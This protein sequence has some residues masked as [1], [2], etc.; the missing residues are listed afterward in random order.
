MSEDEKKIIELSLWKLPN[1]ASTLLLLWWFYS[2]PIRF[3][4][5]ITL[6]NPQTCRKMYVLTFI[7]CIIWIGFVAYLI[8][9]ML[10]VIGK[11]R[12]VL[13]NFNSFNDVFFSFT[14]D[15][16]GIAE[17]ILGLTVLAVGGCTPEMITGAIMA[18]RGQAGTGIA[19][20]LGASS[21]AILLSLGLPWFIKVLFKVGHVSNPYVAVSQGDGVTFTI[22]SLLF[23]PLILFLIISS[24]KFVLRR[25]ASIFMI[26]C[27]LLFVTFAVLVELDVLF[28]AADLC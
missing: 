17:S 20:S 7:L 16:F 12:K 4:L 1:D 15:T 9:W 13:S 28:P 3:V 11:I 6:P 22:A 23:V 10:V 26:T 24:F 18:R 25:I 21:L 19:N 5:T 2:W 14:G 27:Y 8:F